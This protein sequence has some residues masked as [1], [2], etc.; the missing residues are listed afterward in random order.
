MS[1]APAGVFNETSP[2][3]CGLLAARVSSPSHNKDMKV[4]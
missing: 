4:C 1:V 2:A 3:L